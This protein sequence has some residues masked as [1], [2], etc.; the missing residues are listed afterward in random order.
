MVGDI[1]DYLDRTGRAK[2]TLVIFTSD[3]GTQAG[4]HADKMSGPE[5]H[6][7]WDK[8]M[9]Y[10]ESI[11][12]PLILR[13]PGVF[14]GGIVRDTLTAPVDIFPTLCGLCGIPIPRTVEGYNLSAAWQGKPDAFERDA[15]LTMNFSST[16]N[17]LDP[18]MEW[19]GVRTKKHSYIRWLSRETQLFDLEKDPLQMENLIDTKG[20]VSIQQELEQKLTKLMRA[21]QD[22]LKP[23]PDYGN[24]FDSYRRVIR[25]AYGELGDPERTPD[26]SMLN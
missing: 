17:Y 26:W 25:N 6:R 2:D 4:A 10:E 21:R 14:E 5:W 15:V 18:G 24:W 7:P 13:L 9:P 23:C 16:Y 1:L 19:R 20:A 8:K 11:H 3:H 22:E 12:V